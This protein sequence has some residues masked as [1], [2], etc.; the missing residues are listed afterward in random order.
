MTHSWG[1]SFGEGTLG[2]EN[3]LWAILFPLTLVFCLLSLA[4][5]CVFAKLHGGTDYANT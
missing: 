2:Q 4:Q 3:C 5:I 1:G